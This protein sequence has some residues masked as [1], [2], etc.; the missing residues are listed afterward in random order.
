MRVGQL[1]RKLG[2]SPTE[3]INFLT[4]AGIQTQEAS[5]TKL[6]ADHLQ[7]AIRHFDPTGKLEAALQ[8]DNKQEENKQEE[9]K[10][11]EINEEIVVAGDPLFA[12]QESLV[13]PEQ[14]MESAPVVEGT[15]DVESEVSDNK[16]EVI[17]A[18]KVELAGL[19][20]LGKI[21]LPEKKKK[22]PP[23]VENTDDAAASTVE[24]SP[25]PRREPR[26]RNPRH[27]GSRNSREASRK[28]PIALKREQEAAEAER[29][30]EEQAKFEK[31]RRTQHYL[32]K[33]KSVPTK[34]ARLIREDVV[35]LHADQSKTP[36]TWLGKFWRWFRS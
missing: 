14:P 2:I 29:K 17:K 30:R 7:V 25:S 26:L 8:E 36:T 21:E 32:S 28:N 31:E 16:I 18:P 19:K 9:N 24:Q 1:A 13:E 10:Q 33:V 4:S 11:E 6:S 23:V 5:N 12:A 27:Q 3:L 34:P 15:S 22:E 35:E 20:V